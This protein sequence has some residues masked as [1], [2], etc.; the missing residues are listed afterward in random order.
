MAYL[1]I[2]CDDTLI[3]WNNA[4]NEDGIYRGDK[5]EINHGLRGDVEC[6]LTT[7]PEYE[8]VVWSGGGIHYAHRW[9]EMCFP[10]THF[11]ILPKDMRVPVGKDICV[12]DMYGELKPRDKRVTVV[13]NLFPCPI[14]PSSY[15]VS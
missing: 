3:L 10:H 1:F 9:A 5:Y 6:F 7:H 4:K 2:D 12:D 11:K 14:C 15:P 8:L 13:P